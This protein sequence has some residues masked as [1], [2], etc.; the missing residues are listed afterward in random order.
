MHVPHDPGRHPSVAPSS[1]ASRRRAPA[2]R[3]ALRSLLDSEPGLQAVGEAADL[4][5]RSATIRTSVPDAVLVDRARPRRGGPQ[6]TA[7]ARHGGPGR[8]DLPRRHGR[9]PAA[10]RP[11]PPARRGRLHPAGRGPGAAVRRPWRRWPSPSGGLSGAR[12]A[13]PGSQTDTVVPAP[14]ADSMAEPPAER[15]HALAHADEA[16]AGGAGV[17]VE[18]RGPRRATVTVT[19]SSTSRT[20]TGPS[21]RRNA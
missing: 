18:A 8:R 6:S 1:G 11:C 15:L 12:G 14:G 13:G 9:P 5:T 2:T 16:E 20:V 10:G 7:D 21:R 17:R 19:A 3:S 4:L